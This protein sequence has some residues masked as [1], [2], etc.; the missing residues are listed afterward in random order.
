MTEPRTILV[1]EDSATIAIAVQQA[2]L[3]QVRDRLVQ[4]TSPR[5]R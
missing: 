2:D 1:V 4:P 3:A 5:R